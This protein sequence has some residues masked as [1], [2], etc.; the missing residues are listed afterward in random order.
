MGF[1]RKHVFEISSV[2]IC[3]VIE[4][5]LSLVRGDLCARSIEV[6]I[7]GCPCPEQVAG[8]RNALVQVF[9]NLFRNAFDAMPEG[10]EIS[11]DVSVSHETKPSLHV[12]FSDTGAGIAKEHL[13]RIFVPFFTTKETGKGTGL[14]LSVVH[15]IISEHKGSIRVESRRG[16]G[17]SFYIQLPAKE[18]TVKQNPRR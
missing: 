5:S 10:G 1:S 9:V 8:D 12:L 13:E 3:E 7:R 17:T 2:S 14:G 16:S 15:G 11:I 6:T 18:R 4:K